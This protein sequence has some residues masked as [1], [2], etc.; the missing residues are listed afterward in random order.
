MARRVAFAR[1][2]ALDPELL[3]YDEPFTGQ[4]PISMGVLVK[5]IR[6]LNTMLGNT[7]II[8]SHDVHETLSIADYVYIIADSKVAAS[9]TP[10]ELKDT[11]VPLVKQFIQ[12]QADGPISFMYPANDYQ[13]DLLG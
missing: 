9:G 8:V 11:S 2:V 5:L 7:S 12:G 10:E 4:D 6:A 1:A 3:L 13:K